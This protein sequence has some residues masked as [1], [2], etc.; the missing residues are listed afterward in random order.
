[1][2][3]SKVRLYPKR[4]SQAKVICMLAAGAALCLS[5]GLL[6]GRSSAIRSGT[7]ENAASDPNKS[8]LVGTAGPWGSPEYTRV[9]IEPPE[10]L[11]PK[12]QPEKA[13]WFFEGRSQAQVVQVLKDAEIVS[14]RLTMY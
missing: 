6:I 2:T 4:R 12:L 1:M 9:E 10:H 13:R 8:V 14:E 3:V 7:A 5:V 11:I